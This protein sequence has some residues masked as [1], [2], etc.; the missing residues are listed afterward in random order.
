MR[1]PLRRAVSAQ[2]LLATC[3]PISKK[4]HRGE[5]TAPIPLDGIKRSVQ[6]AFDAALDQIEAFGRPLARWEEDCLARALA[7]MT[8]D[9]YDMAAGELKY[10]QSHVAKKIDNRRELSRPWRDRT[11]SLPEMRAGLARIRAQQH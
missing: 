8:C 9:A 1:G 2:G 7:A 11:L 3:A 6:R 5:M 4:A 10:F